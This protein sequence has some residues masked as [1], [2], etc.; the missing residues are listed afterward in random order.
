MIFPAALRTCISICRQFTALHD[1]DLYG[2]HAAHSV[3]PDPA[4]LRKPKTT[5]YPRLS[6]RRSAGGVMVVSLREG[7]QRAHS[8]LGLGYISS[9]GLLRTS[10][11]RRAKSIVHWHAQRNQRLKARGQ[12]QPLRVGSRA[13]PS[14][15]HCSLMLHSAIMGDLRNQLANAYTYPR[16][17]LILHQSRSQPQSRCR[18]DRLM[19]LARF[20]S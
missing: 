7:R 19:Y 2:T 16:C 4:T 6:A 15:E 11:S 12:R 17:V 5:E 20:C 1:P 3:K 10:Q 8:K 13:S 18:H 9:L 14:L